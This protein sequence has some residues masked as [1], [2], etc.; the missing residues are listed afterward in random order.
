MNKQ[1]LR[2]FV[3]AEYERMAN[4]WGQTLRRDGTLESDFMRN[5]GAEAIDFLDRWENK[6]GN[7]SFL[8]EGTEVDQQIRINPKRIADAQRTGKFVA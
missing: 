5:K 1:Q 3:A 6:T 4:E 8:R 7:M 2:E